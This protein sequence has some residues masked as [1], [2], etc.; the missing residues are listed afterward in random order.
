[1]GFF[2]GAGGDEAFED[3]FAGKGWGPVVGGEDGGVEVVVN[4]FQDAD[5]ACVVDF[6]VM[7]FR[8]LAGRSFLSASGAAV[9]SGGSR[10]SAGASPSQVV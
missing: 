8:V 6:L 5:E 10:G 2:G 4:L 9:F 1:M 3:F 7:S